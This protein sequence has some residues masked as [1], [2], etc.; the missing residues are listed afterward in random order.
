MEGNDLEQRVSMIFGWV[1]MFILG[2][3]IF[4]AYSIGKYLATI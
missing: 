2:V 4:I 1:L 3:V